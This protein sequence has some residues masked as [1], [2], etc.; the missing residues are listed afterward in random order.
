MEPFVKEKL[1]E[2]ARL[3][4]RHRV[5]RLELFGSAAGDGFDPGGS[6][7]DF[8]VE[9]EDMAPGEHAHAYFGLMEDL[10]QVFGRPVDLVERRAIR[11]PYFIEAIEQTRV[12][13]YAAG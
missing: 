5:R 6:D 3:C 11:N 2:V 12:M 10:Q 7:L 13:L 4:A 8:L 1:K 9:Y